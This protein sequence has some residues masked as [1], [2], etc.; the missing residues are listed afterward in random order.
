MS[1]LKEKINEIFIK[2]IFEFISKAYFETKK[3]CS[4]I[5]EIV[6]LGRKFTSLGI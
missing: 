4:K 3:K 6:A 5:T 1:F 2:K